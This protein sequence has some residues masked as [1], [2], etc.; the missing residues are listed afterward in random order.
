MR[1]LF[2]FFGS[3]GFSLSVTTGSEWFYYKEYPWVYD[4]VTEDWLYLRGGED[5]KVFAYRASTKIWE[6]FNVQEQ[7]KTW[8][9]KYEEWIQNPEPYGGLE[10]LQLI[11]EA[12]GE[13]L[14]SIDVGD[15][16][17]AN[18]EPFEVF[19]HLTALGIG[20]SNVTDLSPLS[21][22]TSLNLLILKDN[23]NLKD[24]S[25]LSKL[26]SLK[27]LDLRY[28]DLTV[29][30]LSPIFS[31]TNLEKL[32]VSSMRI[33]ET[34][35]YELRN[36]LPNC[37]ITF[38]EDGHDINWESDRL[39]INFFDFTWEEKYEVWIQTP[40]PYGGLSVL[41]QIKEAKDSGAWQ[42]ILEN[43]NISDISPLDGL[44][45]FYDINLEGNKISD[46]SPLSSM[47]NLE[48][49]DLDQ[50]SIIDISPLSG[51]RTLKGLELGGNN[52]SD[53]SAL[54]NLSN[55]NYLD[56]DGNPLSSDQKTLITEALPPNT[57]LWFGN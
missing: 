1:L 53:L 22:M 3:L 24:L 51:L 17:I 44:V 37:L 5:G 18:I 2:A 21:N 45:Q 15:L 49:L 57:E 16:G 38:D 7:E 43:K 6:E 56:L 20:D 36:N 46:I 12:K 39:M 28:N 55:L 4:N 40:E 54:T 33:L 8:N 29:L 50:N 42:I 41:H 10:V 9:E 31:L 34:Q 48:S 52:I 14:S 30:D 47:T 27:E 32:R 19:T 13:A 11:K 26:I 23:M 25:P 35:I